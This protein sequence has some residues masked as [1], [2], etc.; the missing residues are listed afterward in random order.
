MTQ[1]LSNVTGVRPQ[2]AGSVQN[3]SISPMTCMITWSQI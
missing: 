1:R 2:I 3:A